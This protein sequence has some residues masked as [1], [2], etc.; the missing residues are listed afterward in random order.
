MQIKNSSNI[1]G[2][3]VSHHQGDNIDW[4]QVKADGISFA[5]IKATQSTT[6]LDDCLDRNIKGAK[7]AGI[8]VGVYHYAKFIT[9]S[10]AKAE[11]EFFVSKIKDYDIDLPLVLDL[12]D[13]VHK[14]IPKLTLSRL[15]L[16]WFQ[17][18]EKLTG[19][20][21]MLYTGSYFARDQLDN[22]LKDYPLWVAHYN[23]NKPLDNSTWDKWSIWQYTSTGKVDGIDG[24]V[25]MNYMELD[26]WN[27]LFG[28]VKMDYKY[29]TVYKERVRSS[30]GKL[31]HCDGDYRTPATDVRFI[32]FPT[33]KTKFRFVYEK[34]EKVSQLVKKHKADFGI[35][36]PFFDAAGKVLGSNK[37][38]DTVISSPYGKMLKRH[39][40][41]VIDGKPSIGQYDMSTKCDLMV[42]GAPLL[43]ENG[44]LVYEKYRVEEEVPDDIGKSR[45]QRTFVWIDDNGDLWFACGD[46]R[47][48]Y[49]AGL[50]L[51]E[52]ALFAKEHGAITSLNFD[53]GSSV[54]LSDP[55]G[56]LNQSLNRGANESTVNHA[57][58]VYLNVIQ[59]VED[60]APTSDDKIYP[61]KI[62]LIDK[63]NNTT[64]TVN[65]FI[66]NDRSYVE[67]RK[68]SEFLEAQVGWDAANHKANLSK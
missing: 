29:N 55:T 8:K 37:D 34:G 35:N 50:T 62:D 7:N 14:H 48:N 13:E 30:N 38:G 20:K 52:A 63:A 49:D 22:T 5:F 31:I 24:N 60:D 46:G 61:V 28:G 11:A 6:F 53:G 25:D 32:K 15:A 16:V 3:D 18:V 40:L 51:E 68:V 58:L 43:V 56:G 17:T 65:G 66:L 67:L 41:V 12:E 39:E 26:F 36:A 45:C 59:D 64:E 1:L 9:E 27:E 44:N 4:Q 21:T 47:T 23:T 33:G 10:S 54:S 42:Q 19:K 2:L 57:L